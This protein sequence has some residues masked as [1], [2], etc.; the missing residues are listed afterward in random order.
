[1]WVLQ[2]VIEYV[3]CSVCDHMEPP[4]RT[5][6]LSNLS[7]SAISAISIFLGKEITGT[8]ITVTWLLTNLGHC[9]ELG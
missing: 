2:V 3:V 9:F 5:P 8:V 6:R 7:R 1:M 4:Q